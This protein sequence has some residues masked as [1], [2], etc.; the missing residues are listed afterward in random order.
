MLKLRIEE[1]LRDLDLT[2]NAASVKA[3]R[4][5]EYLREIFEKI[6]AGHDV[7]PRADTVNA[8]ARVLQCNVK[9]L[10]SGEG[11]KV[12]A[13][14]NGDRAN[15]EAEAAGIVAMLSDDELA[16][17]IRVLQGLKARQ[18]AEEQREEAQ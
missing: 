8:L 9:W 4:N 15:R 16:L 11:P 18:E 7:H 1:R 14:E 6:D 17:A 2:R 12:Q 10:I 13:R 5:R 3:G